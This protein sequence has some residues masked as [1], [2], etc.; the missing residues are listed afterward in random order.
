[1][2]YII[3]LKKIFENAKSY[4]NSIKNNYNF[5]EVLIIEDKEQINKFYNSKNYYLYFINLNEESI[6][7]LN[8]S[9]NKNIEHL[10][11]LLV[12]INSLIYYTNN[13]A[14]TDFLKNINFTII[15]F[16]II[17]TY[18]LNNF[19]IKNI[20]IPYLISNSQIYN[21]NKIFDVGIFGIDS[22]HKK[23]IY[24]KLKNKNIN[25]NE[26]ININDDYI[27]CRH[28]IIINLYNDKNY[29][30]LDEILF[31]KS[32]L[33]KLILISEK[34]YFNYF[35]FLNEYVIEIQYEL[36]VDQTKF[37][38]D[39][40]IEFHNKLYKNY[41][42][43]IIQS[44]LKNKSDLFFDNIIKN[45]EIKEYNNNNNQNNIN[46][47]IR[48]KFGFI[49]L[50]HVN[51]ELTNNYWIQSYNCIRKFYSNKIIIID[52]NSDQNFVKIDIDLINCEI[53][54]SEY[55]QR[56][57]ILPYYYMYKNNYFDKVCI[58]H[59]SI[60]FNNYINFEDY[61]SVKF[62]WH[63]SHDWDNENNEI[64]LLNNIYSNKELIKFYNNK[65]LWNGCFGVQTV[66]TIDFI[67]L[68]EKKYKIFNLL[69]VINNR[70]IRMAFERIFGLLCSF[71]N[72]ELQ[73]DPSIFGKIHHYIH[74][75]YSYENYIL[76]KLNNKM[77]L[78]LIKVWT[79]R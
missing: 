77:D 61:N 69:N 71:E 7:D 2:I 4:I 21:Y 50:R 27:F 23:Y 65:E 16:S 43:N 54:Q 33:N 44:L 49:I 76:D 3:I 5:I 29:S 14:N 64:N 11:L 34:T 24:N 13:T 79:G 8:N 22:N 72:K 36:I 60:F 51:S 63:F 31:K 32:L 19:S 55:H 26:I 47:P 15:D 38:L 1:M 75:G 12:N 17:N 78:S 39:N 70:E 9:L 53:V 41:N 57:E 59:D 20:Y 42:I 6:K 10:N 68:L 66:I 74:W 48:E 46:I 18:I 37:I 40:Y 45:T 52:D 62:I 25:V 30:I 56:G 28:K 67:E 35:D 58:I 73:K